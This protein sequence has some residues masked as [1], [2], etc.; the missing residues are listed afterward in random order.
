MLSCGAQSCELLLVKVWFVFDFCELANQVKELSL[1]QSS[2]AVQ[3]QINPSRNFSCSPVFIFRV[4]LSTR[5]AL[6]RGD[7]N[8][9]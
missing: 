4:L 6:I 8:P 9:T 5:H 2:Q 1:V 3:T 7:L